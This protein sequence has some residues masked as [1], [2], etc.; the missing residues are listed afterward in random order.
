MAKPLA[1]G[2]VINKRSNAAQRWFPENVFRPG[3]SLPKK[4][5]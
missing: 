4:A 3:A 1:V 5:Y 2:K